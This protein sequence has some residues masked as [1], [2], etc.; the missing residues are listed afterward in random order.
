MRS[1]LI[2]SARKWGLFSPVGRYGFT[3]WGFPIHSTRES[4]K[5]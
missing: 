4:K 2:K 5:S 1:S 3:L